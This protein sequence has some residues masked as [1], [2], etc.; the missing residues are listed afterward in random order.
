MEKEKMENESQT[1]L[2][3][4]NDLVKKYMWWSMGAGLIPVPLVDIAAV[5]A[6]QL[7]MIKDMSDIYGVKFSENK[8]K[9][10]LSALLGSIVPN[11]LARGGVGSILKMLPVVGSVM[12]GVSMSLFSGAST[13]AVG[14]AFVQHFESGGTFLDFDPVKVKDYFFSKFEEGKEIAKEMDEKKSKK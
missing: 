11:S 12:G 4:S 8:G 2:E 9:S 3:R 13:Y 1:N 5:S 14:K 7:K 10:I 6:V